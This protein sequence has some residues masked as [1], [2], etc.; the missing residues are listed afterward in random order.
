MQRAADSLS[1]S[2]EDTGGTVY[3]EYASGAVVDMRLLL[4]VRQTMLRSGREKVKRN[5]EW[6]ADT[7]AWLDA[8]EK[9]RMDAL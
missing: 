3:C 2:K 1:V 9:K 6:Y 7:M 8:S 5:A 4:L